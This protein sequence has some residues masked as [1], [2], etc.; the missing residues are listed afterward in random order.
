MPKIM[1]FLVF[2]CGFRTNRLNDHRVMIA[3]AISSP[4]VF[5]FTDWASYLLCFLLQRIAHVVF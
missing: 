5:P 4:I 3:P 1:K 2:A